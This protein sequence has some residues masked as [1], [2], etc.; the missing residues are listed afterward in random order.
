MARYGFKHSVALRT[1]LDTSAVRRQLPRRDVIPVAADQ[2]GERGLHLAGATDRVLSAHGRRQHHLKG[3]TEGFYKNL[4][5]GKL[6]P[7]RETLEYL[8]HETNVWFEIMLIPGE[9]DSACE[10]E[11]ESVWVMDHLGPDVP[12]H[13]T[14]FHPDW[15]LTDAPP[16]PPQT[17]RMARRI[18]MD[19][20]VNYVYTGNVRNPASQATHC[21]ACGDPP[22]TAGLRYVDGSVTAWHGTNLRCR[23]PGSPKKPY[24]RSLK[25]Y[26]ER[27]SYEEVHHDKH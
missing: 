4:C 6:A 10:I 22:P 18:A 7:V 17:L 9:N 15:K 19:A 13:F 26:G 3:F 2:H 25:L 12:L 11:A 24:S 5:S 16:T 21:H 14:A 1:A 8:K 20:G 23:L 27:R